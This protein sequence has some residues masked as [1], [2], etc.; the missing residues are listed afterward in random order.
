MAVKRE[1]KRLVRIWRLTLLLVL[2]AA[3]GAAFLMGRIYLAGL[4][5]DHAPADVIIVLGAAQYDGTPTP[6]YRGRLEHALALYH[7]GVAPYLLFTGGS[8]PGD[9]FTEAMA[10]RRFAQRRGVPA[11]AIFT[12]NAGHTT[13]ESLQSARDIMRAHHL[14]RAI[15]VSDPFHAF[16]LQHMAR[17]LGLHATVSP[18]AHSRIRS[19][20]KQAYF[21]ARE[22]AVY[23]LYRIFK[24]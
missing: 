19:R 22:A 20:S 12:E 24:T 13:W 3:G 17:D 14:Q 7:E 6:V 9:R 18:A 2:L 8:R 4:H 21:I 10:G 15:L 1:K 11:G 16:R 5:D 23:L